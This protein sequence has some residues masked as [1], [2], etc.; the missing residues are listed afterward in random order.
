MRKTI[1]VAAMALTVPSGLWAQVRIDVRSLWLWE[2]RTDTAP[3]STGTSGDR[4]DV[5]E[6]ETGLFAETEKIL[7]GW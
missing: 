7:R 2:S 1:I 4:C 6:D 5:G 3:R